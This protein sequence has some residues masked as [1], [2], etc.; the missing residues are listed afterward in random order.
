MEPIFP[1]I[2]TVWA[3]F[4]DPAFDPTFLGS[5]VQTLSLAIA[6]QFPYLHRLSI[7]SHCHVE[8]LEGHLCELLTALPSLTDVKVPIYCLTSSVVEVASRMPKL[9]LL[10]GDHRR[11]EWHEMDSDSP[12]TLEMGTFPKLN[13]IAMTR[14]L[15][16]AAR[17]L[18][19]PNFPTHSL[20]DLRLYVVLREGPDRTNHRAV[21]DDLNQFGK[22]VVEQCP[23]LHVLLIIMWP[24]DWNESP[25]PNSL[26]LNFH[27]LAPLLRLTQLKILAIKNPISLHMTDNQAKELALALPNLE[28]LGLAT[29]ATVRH[30]SDASGSLTLL[31][32]NH[33]ATHC[34]SLSFLG[35]SIDASTNIPASNEAVRFPKLT[36]LHLGYSLISSESINPVVLFISRSLPENASLS[37]FSD[38]TEDF[39]ATRSPQE[40]TPGQHYAWRNVQDALRWMAKGRDTDRD[41]DGEVRRL[42]KALAG[43]EAEVLRL[44]E[45]LSSISRPTQRAS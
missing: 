6:K 1:N 13:R 25:I 28:T 26:A 11:T 34:P 36:S 20:D 16:G 4:E 33:F 8:L 44:R 35:L 3:I 18:Q 40:S 12:P 39:V 45:E 5:S 14:T 27:S 43:A 42:E 32:L 19:T 15:G 21:N 7:A 37:V 30:P 17:F 10:D 38:L 22:A 41:L 23:S 24:M 31:S 2:Q 9:R 29:R